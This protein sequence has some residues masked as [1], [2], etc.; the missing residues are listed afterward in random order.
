MVQAG[1]M[2]VPFPGSWCRL[3]GK[4]SLRQGRPLGSP[5]PACV[6]SFF[7]VDSSNIHRSRARQ[8]GT[9][10]RAEE[11]GGSR[12]GPGG[13]GEASADS[14]AGRGE[15]VAPRPLLPPALRGYPTPG[16]P[17]SA[18][19]GRRGWVRAGRSG[20][21]DPVTPGQP[22]LPARNWSW[23]SGP[24]FSSISAAGRLTGSIGAPLC[25]LFPPALDARPGSPLPL[26]SPLC[27][28]PRQIEKSPRRFLS[29]LP[30]FC[31]GPG[32]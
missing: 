17:G 7:L 8:T 4:G 10:H 27:H 2:P 9:Y 15:A 21:G 11:G 32:P 13:A 20:C 22:V 24:R 25:L 31:R 23:V 29:T 16:G 14:R 5:Q 6:S 26:S 18:S 28:H 1:E 12:G 19:C 3:S 30:C